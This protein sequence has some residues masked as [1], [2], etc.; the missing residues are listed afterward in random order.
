MSNARP[1]NNVNKVPRWVF[2]D[3][4]NKT[5]DFFKKNKEFLPKIGIFVH[6]GPAHLVPCW[7]NSVGGLVGGCGAREVSRKT[8]IYFI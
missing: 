2:R 6:F 3:V 7:I 1:K 5:F 4:G 8:P